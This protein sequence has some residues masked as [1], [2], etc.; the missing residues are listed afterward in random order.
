VVSQSPAAVRVEIWYL[1]QFGVIPAGGQ[2]GPGVWRRAQIALRWDAA[3]HD[4][5]ITRDFTFTEGPDPHVQTPSSVE[6]TEAVE[7]LGGAWQMYAD[8]AE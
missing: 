1:Y 8:A 2:P 3:A 6:R 4:W 7:P 5:R